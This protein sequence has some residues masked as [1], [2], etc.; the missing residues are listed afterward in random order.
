MSHNKTLIQSKKNQVA[1]LLHENRL[2]E[3]RDMLESICKV[4]KQDVSS[5]SQ[6]ANIYCRLGDLER[7]RK[8]LQ[9]SNEDL[10]RQCVRGTG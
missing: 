4:A 5:L 9:Q 3:A 8:I 10:A 7:G 6:L 1:R 2:V